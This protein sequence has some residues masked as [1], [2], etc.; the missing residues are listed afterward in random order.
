[1]SK[2]VFLDIDGV[3]VNRASLMN[4][5]N[6]WTHSNCAPECVAALNRLIE[7]TEAAIVVSSVWRI[8]ASLAELRDI[9]HGHFGMKGKVIGKTPRFPYNDIPG[10]TDLSEEM[11][12]M[13]IDRWLQDHGDR[14]AVESFVILDDDSDM[15]IHKD[16]LVQ[17]AFEV[18]LTDANV[19]RAVQVLAIPWR[20]RTMARANAR[21][22]IKKLKEEQ[23]RGTV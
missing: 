7:H 15:G 5:E 23:Q 8:G 19:D 22:K 11:R 10:T 6:K 3:L 13:E 2:I 12:G 20:K 14:Y 16:R 4:R 17:T 1:M 9:L 18:G 21:R